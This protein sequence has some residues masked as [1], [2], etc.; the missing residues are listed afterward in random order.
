MTV[1]QAQQATK[2]RIG[3]FTLLAIALGW[4]TF[5]LIP[6]KGYTYGTQASVMILMAAMFVPA[7]SSVLT[8]LITKEG[9]DRMYLR[10]NFRGHLKEYLLAFFGPSLLL[11]V[12]GAFYFLVFP[13]HLDGE[14]VGLTALLASNAEAGISA[15]TML[16]GVV[17]QVVTIGPVVNL[18]P[19]L[20]EEL[21]WRGYLLP[22]LRELYSD[23]Q[24]YIV[25]GVIWGIW[26]LPAIVMGH[27]YGTDYPGYP[28]A[29]V[30]AMV[31]VCII[32]GIIEGHFTIKTGSVIPA[33]MIHSAVN[34]GAGLPIM[35]AKSGYNPLLGPAITGLVGG[36][37]F[38]IVAAILY[39]KTG[40]EEH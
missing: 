1:E 10:P 7:L 39:F 24:A 21:G 5:L 33:A 14:L 19:T 3:L 38:I 20:G 12:S 9:F 30:L 23:R 29:G 16:L 28:V 34:A 11:L 26:H 8:R 40:R 4:G 35:V 22:K 17:L 36:L 25:S 15:R 31:V 13:H 6:L 37:P 32:L 2:R 18:L 27:N